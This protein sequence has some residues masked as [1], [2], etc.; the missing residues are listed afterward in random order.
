MISR[1]WI[2][3]YARS[4]RD[5]GTDAGAGADEG[6]GVDVRAGVGAG[7]SSCGAAVTDII[8]VPEIHGAS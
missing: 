8:L 7:S 2:A 4:A 5:M 6:A 1:S 3:R